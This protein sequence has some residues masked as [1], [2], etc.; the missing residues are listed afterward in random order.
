MID[1]GFVVERLSQHL[2]HILALKE[3]HNEI[4]ENAEKNIKWAG[5]L[6]HN[7]EFYDSFEVRIHFQ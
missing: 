7:I 5:I 1:N 2:N 4:N 3:L 6:K